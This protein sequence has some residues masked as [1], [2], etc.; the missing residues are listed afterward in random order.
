MITVSTLGLHE[1]AADLARAE[2]RAP[3]A[4]RA[5]IEAGAR[6]VQRSWRRAWSGIHPSALAASV[7]FDVRPGL[8]SIQAEIGP[9]KSLPAGALGNI[10][11]F[12][13]S[14]NAPIPGGLP[15]LDAQAPRLERALGEAGEKLLR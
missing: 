8:G 4:A 2:R 11:E 7:T 14:K 12:G 15:A 1:L 9:D 3:L 10:I 5:A 6:D 13:T